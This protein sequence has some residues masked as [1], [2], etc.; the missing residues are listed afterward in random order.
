MLFYQEPNEL[1]FNWDTCCHLVLCLQ[2]IASHCEGMISSWK[3]EHKWQN[4]IPGSLKVEN[5]AKTDFRISPI[6]YHISRTGCWIFKRYDTIMIKHRWL[7]YTSMKH[8]ILLITFIAL[9]HNSLDTLSDIRIKVFMLL[10]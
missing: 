2:L 10:S 9:A 8:S 6:R 1:A 3:F 4:K 7:I 5:L